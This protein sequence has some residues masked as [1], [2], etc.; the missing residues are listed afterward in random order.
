[1]HEVDV[2]PRVVRIVT[3]G[4]FAL[5]S[6]NSEKP[7]T[8]S[9]MTFRIL[10]SHSTSEGSEDRLPL[11]LRFLGVAYFNGEVIGHQGSPSVPP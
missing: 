4:P 9:V 7:K 8:L 11:T 1:M 6:D 3:V 2:R 5:D 10:S